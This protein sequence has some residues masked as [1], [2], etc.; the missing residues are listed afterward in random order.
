MRPLQISQQVTNRES[1]SLNKYFHEI[2]KVKMV[3]PDEEV[4]LAVRI[5]EGDHQALQ[6]LVRT[7]L[8]FVVSVAKKYQNQGLSLGDL[9]CEGNLKTHKWG[10]IFSYLSYWQ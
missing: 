3:T 8:R 7:N 5:R 2:G 1:L 6:K 10:N 9:I 4:D